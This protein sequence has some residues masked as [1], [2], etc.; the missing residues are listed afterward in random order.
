MRRRKTGEKKV[1]RNKKKLEKRKRSKDRKERKMAEVAS[2]ARWMAG[3]GP[4]T[5]KEIETQRK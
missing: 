5:D 2:K 4:I 3:L 1:E